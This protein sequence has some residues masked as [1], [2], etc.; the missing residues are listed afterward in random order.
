[1]MIVTL[2]V[3]NYRDM[4]GSERVCQLAKDISCINYVIVVDN[5]SNDGSYERLSALK[6]NRVK[7]VESGKNG[8]YSYGY[9]Y[10][11]K[12]AEKLHTD[13]V[14]VCNSDN[15]FDGALIEGCVNFLQNNGICGAVSARQFDAS[16]KEN[17]SA[18]HFPSYKEDLLF[19]FQFYRKYFYKGNHGEEVKGAYQKVDALSGSFTCFRM[20]AL[21]EAG[22]YDEKVFL[23]N[24]ENII[25]KRLKKRGFDTYR[26]NNY[27]YVHDHK[28]KRGI[29]EV[30]YKK[31]MQ[32]LRSGYY[33][34]THYNNIKGGKKLLFWI[35]VH[36]GGIEIF[37]MNI[38]KKVLRGRRTH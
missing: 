14:F 13:Y 20:S 31:I 29:Q 18:W 26:L 15:I 6:S 25:S 1:M 23:Y 12:I 11:F 34:Q 7:V 36:I 24:E 21:G 4:K 33:Y 35:S 8:G 9:N 37:L 22:M 17:I 38:V 10:G 30:D 28:R 3:L 5:A 19:C 32:T 27:S 2:V 16:G